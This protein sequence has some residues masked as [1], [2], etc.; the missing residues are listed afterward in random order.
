MFEKQRLV[1]DCVVALLI[2]EVKQIQ[3]RNSHT[4]LKSI[5][6][7]KPDAELDERLLTKYKGSSCTSAKVIQDVPQ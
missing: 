7:K 6:L 5:F 1:Q 2:T 4:R 3:Y